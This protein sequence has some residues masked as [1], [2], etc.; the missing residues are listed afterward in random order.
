MVDHETH[1]LPLPTNEEVLMCTK[2]TTEEQILLFWKKALEDPEK[3]RIFCL[4]NAELLL[5]QVWDK[6]LYVFHQMSK[7]KTGTIII[8]L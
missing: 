7:Y 1:Q 5:Y 3:M 8:I 2:N 4:V 6:S